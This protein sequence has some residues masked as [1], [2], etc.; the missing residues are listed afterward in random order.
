[1]DSTAAPKTG[2]I[3]ARLAIRLERTLLARVDGYATS[4][5]ALV[6]GLTLSR[7]DAIRALLIMGLESAKASGAG[8]E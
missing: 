6:P 2:T 7:S 8:D 3:D 1:M 5:S 4:M